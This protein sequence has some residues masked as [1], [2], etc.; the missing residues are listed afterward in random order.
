MEV[1]ELHI[2]IDSWEMGI[3]GRGNSHCAG[4]KC[5]PSAHSRNGKEVCVT[6]VK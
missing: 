4:H 5:V 3:P 2:Q 1:T 6:G